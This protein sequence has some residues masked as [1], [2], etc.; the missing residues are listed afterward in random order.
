MVVIAPRTP[1]EHNTF[2]AGS[3]TAL[4]DFR[5]PVIRERSRSTVIFYDHEDGGMMA[6]IQTI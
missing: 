4:V 6:K 1:G 5:D 2:V 3:V